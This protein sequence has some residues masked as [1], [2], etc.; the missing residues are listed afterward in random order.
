MAT[1]DFT[2]AAGIITTSDQPVLG[3]LG[4][5]FG[6]PQCMLDF[7][8]EILSAFPS[9]ILNDMQKGIQEGKALADSVFKDVMRQVFL[10]TGIVEYDTALGRFVF[11]SSS[12][13]K[14]I[15][16]NALQGLNDLQGLGTI[17]GFGAQAVVI[18]QNV[19]SQIDAV[20]NCIDQF[21][22]F[23]ALQKGP[24]A[25]ADKMVGFTAIDPVTGEEIAFD[26]PPPALEAASQVYDDN[27]ETLEQAAGFVA[28]ADNS[29]Q[30]IREIKQARAADPENNPEPVFWNNMPD[31]NDPSK[32]LG[33]AL[34]GL[35]SFK[36]IDC[37][38]DAEGNPIVPIDEGDFN[39]FLDVINVSGMQ[40]PVSVQGQF[41]FSRTGVYYDSYGGGLDYSGCITN[42]V[43]AI[44]YDAS[45][46]PRAGTG[47]PPEALKYLHEYNPNIGG[48]GEIVNWHTF[49][50]WAN[51]AFD[52]AYIN[53]DPQIQQYYDTDHFL[54]VLIDNRNREVYDLSSYIGELKSSGYTEDSAV[55]SNQRQVLFS[56]IADHDHK[57]KRRKKQIE[58][59]VLLAPA[60][61]PAV[62]GEIPINT[63][64]NLDSGLISVEQAKQENLLFN[65]GEVS[66]VV[67]PLCPTFIKSEIPQDEFT[68]KDLIVPEVGVGQ[69]ITSDPDASGTSGTVLS[70]TDMITTDQLAAVYNFLDADLVLPDSEKFLS[71]NCA[72]SSTFEAPAQIVASS[73]DSMF[74]SGIG[75]PY[76]R[77][78]CN[79]FSGVD[80]DGNS[81]ADKKV[82]KTQYLYSAYRPYGYARLQEGFDNLDSIL[83]RQSGATF[84]FWTHVPDL[85]NAN[86]PGWNADMSLSS[87]HR[88]V[89]GCENR[90]GTNTGDVAG[91]A[92]N[93]AAVKGLLMGFT[94]DRRLTKNLPPTNN[95]AD[96]DL[97]EGLVFHMSPTQSVNTSSVT[98]LTASGDP[99]LCVQ[100][101][102]PPS[103]YFGISVDTST[104]TTGGHKFNDCSTAFV[105]TAVTVDYG[106]DQVT[107]YLNGEQLAT[108]TVG[109]T[110]GTT[111]AVPP[112]IPSTVDAS[113]FSYDK[114]FEDY[115][116][117]NA[118]LFPPDSLGFRD[119]WWW[120]GPT[121]KVIG[122]QTALTPWII[123]GGYTDGMHVID[124]P[125]TATYLAN[126]A[127]TN[128][129]MNFMG[130]EYGGKK[131]GLH[132]FIG[133]LKLYNK[134]L[135][136]G[137]VLKNYNAQKGF[138]T[139]IRTYSY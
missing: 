84:D 78:V 81:K 127:G 107:I 101:E 70:L 126:Y 52:L 32:T 29:L 22:S 122:G 14:G 72:T 138:F 113:S 21:K 120:D 79:F 36:L 7:T 94:R 43:S 119:F 40:P 112:N 18:G 19:G 4:A 129:G 48:K 47:V 64:Q 12:S 54:Q 57:I 80:G 58:L 103:G 37:E 35:T 6:V 96:N 5:Q 87:L 139:N 133:S 67:L 118:P 1:F 88:V 27:K 106:A 105:H 38:T 115:L 46:Q 74:P 28:A 77:G 121:P 44:Y 56:K 23:N 24:S 85:G 62:L 124:F 83:Y 60:D 98:F 132:G 90:G 55:L 16:Q 102:V 8:K 131:S 15:E 49:N 10:D 116:P 17:L 45:G 71:I 100:D 50:K 117:P 33:D 95:P 104:A 31:P 97:T 9:P 91:A 39:P 108:A 63:F 130:G 99:A 65:P 82:D 86:D 41:L 134:A 3:A 69:I 125:D 110:F 93:S 75:V 76:F 128:Q 13:N 26:A 11:V 73:V 25:I 109:E 137:E 61:S 30:A 111:E 135:S 53:E 34:S 136:A 51:T 42:I 92:P 68:V 2:K 114:A 20:K 123:G 89:L 59:Q 66:G